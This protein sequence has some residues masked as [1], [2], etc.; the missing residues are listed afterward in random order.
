MPDLKLAAIRVRPILPDE[1]ARFDAEL[2]EHHWLGSNLVGET[3][4]HV[5][6][7]PQGDWVALVGFGAA[8]LACKPR[9]TYLG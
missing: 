9:D 5:A 8:A 3:M 4:R 1:R 6:L 7:G 2:E